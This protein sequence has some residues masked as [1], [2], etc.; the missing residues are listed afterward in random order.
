MGCLLLLQVRPTSLDGP[1][2]LPPGLAPGG[3]L[4]AE[5][6]AAGDPQVS[7]RG[8]VPAA[9][10]RALLLVVVGDME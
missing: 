4:L 10:R 8:S 6:L 1:W 2:Q 7:A 5:R 9:L 3:L